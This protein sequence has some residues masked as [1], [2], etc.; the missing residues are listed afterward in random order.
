VPWRPHR[1]EREG[2]Q[3]GS[4]VGGIRSTVIVEDDAL[5]RFVVADALTEA[6]FNVVETSVAM[7]QSKFWS[8]PRTEYAPWF[9]IS[10]CP[11]P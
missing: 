2:S 7:S 6:G 5:T 9:P 10:A 8:S 1:G 3:M 11:A 4:R